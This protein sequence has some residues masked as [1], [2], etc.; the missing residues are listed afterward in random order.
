MEKRSR[1]PKT[2]PEDATETTALPAAPTDAAASAATTG[3]EGGD[4][5]L[6]PLH[7]GAAALRQALRSRTETGEADDQDEAAC[8]T[9]ASAWLVHEAL[10]DE[11]VLS[12]PGVDGDGD[13]AV[14]DHRI[15]VDTTKILIRVLAG[16]REASRRAALMRALV[17]R[18]ERLLD[19]EEALE[20]SLFARTERRKSPDLAARIDRRR[21]ALERDVMASPPMLAR[22]GAALSE[23]RNRQENDVMRSNDNM[24][25]RDEQGRFVSDDVRQGRSRSERGGYESSS[26]RSSR[27]DDRDE[28]GRFTGG[29]HR[30]DDGRSNGRDRDRDEYGRFT[31]DRDD[32]DD[33]GRHMSDRDRDDRGRFTSHRD[34]DDRGSRG[35]GHGGWF[36]DREGHR[37]AAREGSRG[38]GASY[39]DDRRYGR[40]DRDDDDRRGRGRSDDYDDRD[41]RARDDDDRQD[42]RGWF[43][44]RE[45]HAE[46]AREGWRTRR[47]DDDDDGRSRGR[48]DDRD[49]RSGGWFGDARGHA[50]AA[51][52]GWQN[53]R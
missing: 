16:A 46:A 22:L 32:R 8:R 40:S 13:P 36:G 27:N 52:R 1:D 48:D 30:D 25:E 15:E 31:S 35:R 2:K 14:E 41:M 47:H 38:R 6:R 43:G 19:A 10:V 34:D 23:K 9:I 7:D 50:E 44:D 3:E 33:R 45:G 21:A 29:R 49:E 42:R 24:R 53:R 37:E 28:Y 12:A 17:A 39:D 18:I 5:P 11:F 4:D 51:R 26:R 20:G